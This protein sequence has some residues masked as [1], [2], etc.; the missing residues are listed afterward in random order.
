MDLK[1]KKMKTKKKAAKKATRRDTMIGRYCIVGNKSY[2]LYC[3]IIE[4]I[5]PDADGLSTVIVRECRHIARWY[6]KTG[7]VTSLAAHGLCG[8]RAAESR[9]GAPCLA[10]L[11]G[12]VSILAVSHEAVATFRAA[13]QS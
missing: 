1:G 5:A 4:S 8:P 11:S 2:G 10:R 3:G 9:V 13:V 7:G 12:V 6:G